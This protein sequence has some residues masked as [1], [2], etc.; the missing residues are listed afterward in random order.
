MLNNLLKFVE[1]TIPVSLIMI[2]ESE[3]PEQQAQPFEG[4]SDE[5]VIR[6]MK[7]M[8]ASLRRKGNTIEGAR[9]II[10]NIQPFN[11]FPQY[12]AALED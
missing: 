3:S 4:V 12:L 9:S 2:R 1:E 5:P 8:F 11:Q 6:T 7:A 10:C